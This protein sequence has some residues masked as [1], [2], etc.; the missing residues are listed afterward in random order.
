MKYIRIKLSEKEFEV[1]QGYVNI[2][3]LSRHS[4]IKEVLLQDSKNYQFYYSLHR[5]NLTLERVAKS[6]TER[7]YCDSDVEIFAYL[8]TIE[9][10]LNKIIDG[11]HSK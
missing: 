8:H 10:Q 7:H 4:Y 1:L 5:I 3:N 2:T 11:N 9:S 6:I